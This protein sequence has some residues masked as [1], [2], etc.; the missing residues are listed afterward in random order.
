MT[1]AVVL[2]RHAIETLRAPR[3]QARWAMS[4]ALS[5]NERWQALAL[6]SVINT[7]LVLLWVHLNI[8]DVPIEGESVW[9][10]LGDML[11]DNS[12]VV[13]LIQICFAVLSV[14]AF[15][16]GGRVFGGH[17]D[18]DGA[19]SL[20]TWMA[21]VLN[22]ISLLQIVVWLI[23]PVLAGLIGMFSGVLSF[24]LLTC[25]CAEL[26]GF[27]SLTLTFIGIVF[28]IFAIIYGFS[29]LISMI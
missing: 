20:L 11:L 25:F 21:F 28:S 18:L 19:I 16:W 4:I 3:Q 15:H 14:F 13:G 8:A 7:L 17:G 9:V 10:R 23:L 1:V 27:R 29:L 26:H 12:V 2:I 6:N 24:V 22:L 5:R